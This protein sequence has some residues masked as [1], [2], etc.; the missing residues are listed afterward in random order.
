MKKPTIAKLDDGTE[1]FYILH[2]LRD[3]GEGC[4]LRLRLIFPAAAPQ[5]FFDDHAE[6][7]T[8]ECRSG[9]RLAYDD[10]LRESTQKLDPIQ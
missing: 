8:I 4:L 7:L 1:V 2:D 5:V 9:V 10:L 3:T 6:H